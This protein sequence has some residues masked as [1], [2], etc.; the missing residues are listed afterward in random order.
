[1]KPLLITGMGRTLISPLA[2]SILA[3]ADELAYAAE[4]VMGKTAGIPVAVVRNYPYKRGSGSGQNLLVEAD[5]GRLSG[6]F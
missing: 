2:V 1:M 4:L 5:F 3:I 6:D